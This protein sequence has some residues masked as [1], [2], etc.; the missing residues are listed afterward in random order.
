MDE[1]EY[2]PLIFALSI[3]FVIHN[4]GN[5]IHWLFCWLISF[6]CSLCVGLINVCMFST[7]TL[8]YFKFIDMNTYIKIEKPSIESHLFR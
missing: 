8:V 4:L 2:H 6:V 3:H 1:V 7:F 5:Q